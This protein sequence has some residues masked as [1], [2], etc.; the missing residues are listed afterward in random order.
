VC[1]SLPTG[2]VAFVGT[3]GAAGTSFNFI[4]VA[5]YQPTLRALTLTAGVSQSALATSLTLGAS[6]KAAHAFSA[7][8]AR[9]VANGGTPLVDTSVNLP[10]PP[11][12]FLGW[13]GVSAARSLNGIIREIAF[14][15]L[16]NIPDSALQRMTR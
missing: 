7:S 1:G 15:P 14:I 13:D 2:N 9:F 6:H 8:G 10:T 5:R 12:L 16:T 3:L 11:T 4:D